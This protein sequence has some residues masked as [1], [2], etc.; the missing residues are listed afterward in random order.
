MDY[1]NVIHIVNNIVNHASNHA[2]K[3]QQHGQIPTTTPQYIKSSYD[4]MFVGR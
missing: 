2:R 3:Y 1:N 4:W